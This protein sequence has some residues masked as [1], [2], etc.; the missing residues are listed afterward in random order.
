MFKEF[1]TLGPYIKRY[2]GFY[3]PGIIALLLTSG[4]QILIPQFIR[5]AIDLIATGD[6]RAAQ[7]LSL[8]GMLVG[9][10]AG[11]SLFR[12]GWRM[13]IQNASRRIEAELR[14]QY[15]QK[16]LTLSSSF[17]GKN[18]TGDLMARATNDM[19]AVRM[20]TSLALVAAFD[21]I[22]MTL[23]ILILLFSRY[24]RL[25]L[26]TI[27][28]LPV[29]T[30]LILGLG[31]IIGEKFRKVQEGFSNL[32]DH[33]QEVFSGIRVV[34]SFVKEKY[35][36]RKFAAANDDYQLKNME[37][38]RLWGLFFPLVAFLSGITTILLLRL[39]GGMVMTGDISAG[40][41]VAVLA[42]LEM[43][44]WPML[45]AGFTVNL[46]QRGAASLKRINAVLNE[47]PDI[48]TPPDAV[49]G[50]TRGD[51]RITRLSYTYPGTE[52]PVL[53]DVSLEVPEG[54]ILGIL[55]RTGSGKTTLISML[56]RILDPPEGTVF[57]NG[58]DVRRFDLPVLRKSFG[59]V[60]QDSFL[61][62]MSLRDNISFGLDDKKEDIV[63]RVAEVST[64]NRDAKDFYDGFNT[65]VGERGIT[66]SGGQKQRVA[67]SRALAVEA[68]ILV[69]D[70]AL[71]AVDTETEE[72]ILRELLEY[73]KGKT[74]II[75]SHRVSTLSTA[76]KIIVLDNGRIIQE[77]THEELMCA[78][79]FYR[80]IYYLQSFEV[81]NGIGAPGCDE[82]E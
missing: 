25:T 41:F 5:R 6:F 70:D 46:L 22:F 61:F 44:I 75:V 73:R 62:S 2:A 42:Y 43:L 31:S 53:H 71:S 77:G 27:I 4:G 67:I 20:A 49:N 69:F 56:P 60:P 82:P 40:D 50:S 81:K 45:G 28:P 38:V 39:G 8:A 64:I 78:E 55:G 30:I 47:K 3:I 54:A 66:L 80:E 24:P 9:T 52:T 16:L 58:T 23:S 12:F 29:I 35:F 7:I 34:K 74:S 15:F 19:H 36:L 11:I 59:F 76:D 13:L 57:L 1:R 33:A 63:Q 26:Y 68:D 79:G 21:G 51:L 48:A 32:S 65:L 10:A 72:K 37:L 14:E 18:K 17:F